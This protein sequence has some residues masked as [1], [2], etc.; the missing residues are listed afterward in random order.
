MGRIKKTKIEVNDNSSLQS[1][2][3]EVYNNAK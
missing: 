1:V 3:Q 2:M